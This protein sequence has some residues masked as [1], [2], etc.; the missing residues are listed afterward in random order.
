MLASWHAQ[1]VSIKVYKERKCSC[2]FISGGDKPLM[3]FFVS[4]DHRSV[5][6]CLE[7][8]HVIEAIVS[9]LDKR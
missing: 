4:L 1:R 5:S 6:R 3:A 2:G 7:I 9:S 8:G